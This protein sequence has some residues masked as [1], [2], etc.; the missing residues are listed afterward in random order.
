MT[1]PQQITL[2]DWTV[3][4]FAAAQQRLEWQQQFQQL[5]AARGATAASSSS[6]GSSRS[7]LRD[8]QQ[9]PPNLVVQV[10]SHL[11]QLSQLRLYYNTVLQVSCS[12]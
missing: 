4:G 10:A 1:L 6:R 12:C 8:Q 7:V 5:S 11:P 3:A 9:A 2:L